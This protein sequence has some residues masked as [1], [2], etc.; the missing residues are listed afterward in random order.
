[1][2]CSPLLVSRE[3]NLYARTLENL[4]EEF[5]SLGVPP[6]GANQVF[7]WIYKKERRDVDT[8]SNVSRRTKALLKN[9]YSWDVPEIIWHGKSKDGTEKFLLK[10]NDGK[11]IESV[12]I[13]SPGRLTLCLSSQV[14]CAI[15]C[16][17]C[18]TG[19]M[20]LTRNLSA[21][22][23]VGQFVALS[24]WAKN[25]RY[26]PEK[27]T[28]VVYMGQGEPLHNFDEVKKSVEIFMEDQGIG[29]GQRKITL[30]TSGLVP[31][32]ERLWDFPP[33]NIAIS[34]HASHN[35]V[36]SALMPINNSFDL[37]KLF[38]AIQSIPI[39]A[40]RWITYEYILIAGFNDRPRDI[41]G[42]GKLLDR[43][44][45]KINLIPFNEYPQSS[46]KRPSQKHIRWFQQELLSRGYTCTVR[47]TKGDD[48]LAA[49][50][51]LHSS[52]AH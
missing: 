7:R 17:F 29:L 31:K 15:G 19:T 43:K 14:G 36:R 50:G 38:R 28:N 39:K 40:H 4:R 9:L 37:D 51:Q 22:E 47:T 34:L 41:E 49:C 27:I 52:V 6:Y 23:I 33:V 26:P 45:S 16:R 48:I 8:W 46:F 18:Y 35:N 3:M 13:P 1:M 30:S 2:A 21:G 25:H 42:L 32:I 20:G 44:K 24:S 12:L 10:L 11:S 5:T